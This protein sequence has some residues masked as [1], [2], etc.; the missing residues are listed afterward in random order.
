M[1]AIILAGGFGTRLQSVVSDVP[2]PMAPVNGI[3]FLEYILKLL[4]KHGFNRI[5]MAVGYKSEVIINYF[6]NKYL[7]MEILYSNEDY[8]LG[9]GGCIKKALELVSDEY[10]YIINGDTYFDVNLSNMKTKKDIMIACKYMSNFDRYGK[11]IIENNRIVKFQEK[12][13]NQTGYINGGIYLFKKNIFDG[14]NLNEKFSL[15]VDFFE[16]YINELYI[17][18]FLSDDYF[19]D[20]GIP[21]DYKK[22]QE[23]LR[24]IRSYF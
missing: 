12:M 13:P 8:P 15:E 6:G 4:K 21:D 1:E 22:F 5:I 24:W 18:P 20:I 17:E 14:F 10:V 7:D 16:K 19:I 2:K 11:V 23:D 9:T 3:P